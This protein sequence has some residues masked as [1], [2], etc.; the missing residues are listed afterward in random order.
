MMMKRIVVI[1]AVVI[2]FAVGSCAR[3]TPTDAQSP[4]GDTVI[5]ADAGDML[6]LIQMAD[7]SYRKCSYYSDQWNCLNFPALPPG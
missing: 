2:G 7:G 1:A 3:S 6:I 4:A 5:A